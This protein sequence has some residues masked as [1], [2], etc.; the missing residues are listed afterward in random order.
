VTLAATGAISES[1]SDAS[2]DVT[3]GQLDLLA[4]TGIGVGNVIET[5][6]G[7][8]E[9]QTDTGGIQITNTAANLFIGGQNGLPTPNGLKVVTSGDIALINNGSIH[10]SDDDG[11]QTVLG[12]SVSGN[13]L[14]TA[15]GSNSDFISGSEVNA[16]RAPAGSVGIGAGRDISF[17]TPGIGS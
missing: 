16:I 13:V 2:A 17:F 3:A 5:A 8:L 12:G 1:G 6:V 14:L 4:G 10:L 9:A 11:A 15:S 7:N